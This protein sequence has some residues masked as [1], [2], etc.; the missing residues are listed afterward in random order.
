MLAGRATASATDELLMY[1]GSEWTELVRRAFEELPNLGPI[2]APG[3][4]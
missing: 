2:P 3:R 4:R 1:Q